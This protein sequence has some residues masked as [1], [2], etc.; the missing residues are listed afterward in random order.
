MKAKPIRIKQWLL[1]FRPKTLTAAVVPVVTTTALVAA[2]GHAVKWWVMWTAIFSAICIQVAT[3]LFNDAIDFKKGADTAERVGPTRL[4]ASGGAAYG[5]VIGIAYGFLGLALLLGIPLVTEGGWPIVLIGLMSLFMGYAYTGG[6]FPLAYR[7][8]GDLFV[9]IFFG[10]VAVGGTY[11]LHTG[12]YELSA[13]IL[14]LEI[15]LLAT[16]LIAINNLRDI[17]QDEKAKKR[18][19]AVRLGLRFSRVEIVGLLI[20]PFFLHAYWYTRGYTWAYL[21]VLPVFFLCWKV[22]VGV[23]KE[24]PSA[25][26]NTLLA[27]AAAIHL[28]YGALTTLGFMIQA[29]GRS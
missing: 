14:G 26:Y 15:G 18:T 9:L 2:E 3:N 7:G 1:A 28:L 6:P 29:W 10:L 22:I 23:S 12:R 8:L 27:Q 11:F 16:V 13:Q 20:T 25:R 5:S 4:T 19:L 17:Y 21:L 24:K